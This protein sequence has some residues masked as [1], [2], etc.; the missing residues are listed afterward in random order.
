MKI[1]KLTLLSVLCGLSF[2][3]QAATSADSTWKNHPTAKAKWAFGK[4]TDSGQGLQAAYFQDRRAKKFTVGLLGGTSFMF[5]DADKIQTGSNFA[6]FIKYSISQTFAIRAEYNFS[7]LKGQRDFQ[8]PTNYKDYYTF[9]SKLN[10]WALVAQATLGNISF[11]RPLRKT[12]MYFSAGIGQTSFNT[13][14]NFIDQRTSLNPNVPSPTPNPNLGNP[15][16]ENYQAKKMNGVFGFGFKHYLNKNFDLGLEYRHTYLRTDELD[17]FNA[18][19]FNNRSFDSY[20]YLRASIGYKFGSKNAQHY[21]WLSPVASIYE[22]MAD[23]KKKTDCLGLD[24]DKDHVTNCFDQ[25][26]NTPDSCMV[27]GNGMAVDTDMDGVPDCQDKEPFTDKGATVD[28][29]TGVAVD[30]DGDGISDHKDRELNSAPGALVDANGIEIKMCCNCD[31]V[32]FPPIS[33]S[34]NCLTKEVKA[35]LYQVVDKMKQCPD[36]KLVMNGPGGKSSKYN[37]SANTRCMDEMIKFMIE[38][39]GISRDRIITNYNAGTENRNTIELKIQ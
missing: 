14:S 35:L 9:E 19:V 20:A 10:D 23:V 25:D 7:K 37:A 2:V 30:S 1:F 21:D 16:T 32:S 12:Q 39:F 22:Q 31:N 13:T 24:D 27:Y 18:E 5:G 3:T 6:P 36:K 8:S 34:S 17:L 38:K 29:V 28:P 11:L 15:T 33:I 4:T 26:N